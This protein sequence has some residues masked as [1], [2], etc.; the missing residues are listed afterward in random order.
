M[1]GGINDRKVSCTHGHLPWRFKAWYEFFVFLVFY[2]RLMTFVIVDAKYG[3][4]PN[5]TTVASYLRNAGYATAIV[6]KWHL[7]HRSPYLPTNHG[8]DEWLGIPYHMS[9]GSLDDHICGYDVNRTMWLPLYQ[10]D[11]IVEQPVEL[12]DLAQRYAGASERFIRKSVSKGQPFFLYLPF[13]HVH[14][15]CAPAY[16]SEQKLCQWASE[17]FVKEKEKATFV[18]AVEEMDWIAGQVLSVLDEIGIENNTLVLFTSDNGP[19]IA[20]QECSGSKGPFEG[21]W[22]RENVDNACT[23]CPHDYKSSPTEKNRRRCY[24]S[25]TK[26]EVNGVP[27]GEDTGLGGVWEVRVEN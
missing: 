13:S 19:W 14:Q 2:F 24:N 18:D 15:M 20:E 23:A 4:M 25:Q 8:F 26:L 6:G 22:L 7:G 17:M 21:R 5:E 12:K 1:L 11:Q 10:D 9:G 16:G 3:L 27:C